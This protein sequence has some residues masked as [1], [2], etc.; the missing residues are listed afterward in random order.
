M[1]ISKLAVDVAALPS[2]SAFDAAQSAVAK[3][4]VTLDGQSRRDLALRAEKLGQERLT[5]E[6][7]LKE[8][9]RVID[10]TNAE[11]DR[12]T[13]EID[14]AKADVVRLEEEV[15]AAEG[16]LRSFE[17]EARE[18]ARALAEANR[19]KLD[20]ET[21]YPAL[22]RPV[23][24]LSPEILAW[25]E[26]FQKVTPNPDASRSIHKAYFQAVSQV[27]DLTLRLRRL[28]TERDK[29]KVEIDVKRRALAA[30]RDAIP[31]KIERAR[32]LKQAI[33]EEHRAQDDAEM[34]LEQIAEELSV[35][36]PAL[37]SVE[38]A[39]AR[40]AGMRDALDTALGLII[41]KLRELQG[42]V[43]ALPGT[44]EIGPLLQP[45]ESYAKRLSAELAESEFLRKSLA[46]GDVGLIIGRMPGLID[47]ADADVEA[48]NAAARAKLSVDRLP[49]LKA[50][51]LLRA[52]TEGAKAH[53]GGPIPPEDLLVPDDVLAL[54]EKGLDDAADI[55]ALGP[56]IDARIA[57]S[58][59]QILRGRASAAAAEA[60]RLLE[61]ARRKIYADVV[62]L[63]DAK[64]FAELDPAKCRT[65]V[66]E[67]AIKVRDGGVNVATVTALLEAALEAQYKPNVETWKRVL[68]II[69]KS[70]PDSGKKHDG[71]KIHV[72]FFKGNLSASASGGLRVRN[73]NGSAVDVPALLTN[74]LMH[75]TDTSRVHATLEVNGKPTPKVYFD[76]LDTAAPS[77][78]RYF[79]DRGYGATAMAEVKAALVHYLNTVIK[80][81]LQAFVDRHGRP[82]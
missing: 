14:A 82:A 28:E 79:E 57:E 21:A 16:L 18:L 76:G 73:P 81:K 54:M 60:Q 59:K 27:Q 64:A 19:A 33:A 20:L 32:T 67:E 10:E 80:P 72:S 4:A 3:P 42:A 36:E 31:A 56:Q 29:L 70:F 74:L 39:M 15:P 69:G 51:A 34:R 7:S 40:V 50:D 52:Q 1:P 43:A 65:I 38:E 63:K 61:E 12:L 11:K 22:A 23:P 78:T 2:Y 35:V 41:A 55:S 17:D 37:M 58:V 30:A 66:W 13:V 25:A 75:A 45:P 26:A 68:G 6:F 48:V 62:A 5:L 9:T 49:L 44:A 71:F 8:L 47:G 46:K 77:S 53:E 24:G